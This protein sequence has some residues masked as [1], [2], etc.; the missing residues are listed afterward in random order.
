MRGEVALVVLPVRAR[1]LAW[2]LVGR[3]DGK[4]ECRAS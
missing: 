2:K 3:E 4:R 1:V